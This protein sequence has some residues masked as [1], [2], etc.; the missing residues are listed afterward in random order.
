M[1]FYFKIFFEA[2]VFALYAFIC[3]SLLKPR[4]A[5]WKC[6]LAYGG[7]LL[8]LFGAAAAV[9]VMGDGTA[10]LTLLPVIVY[11]PFSVCVYFLS[12]GGLLE[13]AVACSIGALASIIIKSSKRM[14]SST[15]ASLFEL[16][17]KGVEF[18]II[19]LIIMILL[20][21]GIAFAVLRFIRRPFGFYIR[22]ASKNRLNVLIP[23]ATVFLLTFYNFNIVY[24]TPV[25]V[26]TLIIAVSFFAI[27]SQL[28]IYSARIT[29]AADNEKR[30]SESLNAQRQSFERLSEIVD[31]GRCFRHDMRHHLKILSGMAQQNNSVEILEY[32]KE[33]NSSEGFSSPEIYCSNSAI[34]AVFS[35]GIS[36]AKRLGCRIEHKIF[37][38]EDIPFE[39]PDV[40]IIFSNALENALNACEKCPEEKRYLR[41]SAGFSDDC[42]LTFYVGNPCADTVEIDSE[43]FPKVKKQ[44]DGH[45]IGLRGVDKVVRKYNGFFCCSCENGEFAFYAEIFR[46]LSCSSQNQEKEL[47]PQKPA[48][49]LTAILSLIV[50]SAVM[51]NISP[52]CADALSEIL[53]V[54]IKTLSYGW[55]DS[56]LDIKYPE[57]SGDGSDTANAAVKDFVSEAR[58]I[59]RQHMLRKYEGYVAEEAGYRIYINDRKYLSARF[60]ATVNLG[61]S[62]EYSRCVVI[63]KEN[64]R[65]LALSD[66]FGENRDYIAEISAE[67]LRQMEDRVEYQHANY[68]IPGGIWSEDECFKEI[69]PDQEF[70]LTSDGHLVI[71]FE[72]YTVAAGTEGS[73]EFI[74]P[75][76]IFSLELWG[77]V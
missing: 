25:T 73:P 53:S 42:K 16:G 3:L 43:G 28:F 65:E 75:D 70:Y 14:L 7:V 74:M 68:F 27:V 17:I 15:E 55:G 22:S 67:V 12:E 40:C 46:T 77:L 8:C 44:V 2:I 62:F 63:D 60:F 61:G 24:S 4:F 72:E 38:P 50:C 47:S 23:A 48:K 29:E 49:A 30:L 39:T 51:L 66:L 71:V 9:S 21:S 76:K 45:G 64:D 5:A 10:A 36:R 18:D 33:L 37:I 6:A 11:L 35:E 56:Y 54:D 32:I 19:Q 13:T 26:L 31:T 20:A 1:V 57:F 59:F 52:L 69:S 41:L 58:N 34:N